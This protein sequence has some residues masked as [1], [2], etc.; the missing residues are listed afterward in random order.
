MMDIQLYRVYLFVNDK[1]LYGFLKDVYIVMFINVKFFFFK[2]LKIIYCKR[3]I[4][5]N[6]I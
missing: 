4:Y 3:Y 5:K 2:D 6:C 1:F